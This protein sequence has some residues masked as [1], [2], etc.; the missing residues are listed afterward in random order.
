[1]SVSVFDSKM[2]VPD[3][4]MLVYELGESIQ[5]LNLIQSEIQN[6]FGDLTPEWKHYGAKSG[7]ILKLFSKK[8]NVLFVIP[9]QGFFKV[10]FTF[11]D[12]AA[13]NILEGNFPDSK[14]EELVAAKKFAEGRTIQLEVKTAGQCEYILEIIHIKMKN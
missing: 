2:V 14:K 3:N 12:K 10:A 1:M 9:L 4:K 11:G 5:Y 6:K 7:W 8:R 13:N